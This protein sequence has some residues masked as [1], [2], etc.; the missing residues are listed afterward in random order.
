MHVSMTCSLIL[1]N[2]TLSVRQREVQA[3]LSA[4]SAASR[5]FLPQPHN[6]IQSSTIQDHEASIR[7][8][9]G[10]R[11][12]CSAAGGGG[13][14]VPLY[15]DCGV[16]NP[17][18]PSSVASPPAGS[19]S[20]LSRRKKLVPQSKLSKQHRQEYQQQQ[21]QQQ[22]MFYGAP[23]THDYKDLMTNSVQQQLQHI[24]LDSQQMQQQQQQQQQQRVQ[25]HPTNNKNNVPPPASTNMLPP[26]H[27]LA[28]PGSNLLN[29][30]S[31]PAHTMAFHK[32]AVRQQQQQQIHQIH[33]QQQH[34]HKLRGHCD[35]NPAKKKTIQGGHNFHP[36]HQHH[37]NHQYALQEHDYSQVKNSDLKGMSQC[38]KEHVYEPPP[39]NNET[40][41]RT[42]PEPRSDKSLCF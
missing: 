8:P 16:P 18:A 41:F 6:P 28:P 7:V 25:Q 24:H 3:E 5:A 36:Q 37:I 15:A 31:P 38:S 34:H 33:Q 39:L 23:Q 10:D 1:V 4:A 19:N 9:A 35:S 30:M 27:M 20:S 14:G 42:F 32:D 29:H 21:Q 12:R 2:F 26:K 22:T 40:H 11:A 17:P 13:C